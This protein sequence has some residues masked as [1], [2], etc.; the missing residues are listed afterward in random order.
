MASD[1]RSTGHIIVLTGIPSAGKTTVADVIGSFQP[2]FNII[3][4]DEG[5]RQIAAVAH[6]PQDAHELFLRL[7]NNV[8]TKAESGDTILEASLPAT[9]VEEA[10]GRLGSDGLFVS[11]RVSRREWQRREITRNDRESVQWNE[12]LTALQG[13]PDLYDLTLDTSEL[14]PNEC[15]DAVL[16]KAREHWNWAEP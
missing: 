13:S 9:Y 2:A 4:G 16:A 8:V 10:R 14:A 7:L 5:L 15:A 6:R 12:R 11:L 1:V 3:H